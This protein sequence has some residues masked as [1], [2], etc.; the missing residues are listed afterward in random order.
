MLRQNS[1]LVCVCKDFAVQLDSFIGIDRSIIR[2]TNII[3]LHIAN[4]INYVANVGNIYN[5][6]NLIFAIFQI[7]LTTSR[8]IYNFC[9]IYS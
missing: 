7:L 5:S 8:L 9:Q 4:Y 6:P 3:M 1:I 2:S